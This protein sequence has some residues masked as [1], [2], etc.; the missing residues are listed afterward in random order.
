M[1]LKSKKPLKRGFKWFLLG[2]LQ[3]KTKNISQQALAW[4]GRTSFYLWL[5]RFVQVFS[6]ML[7]D[8]I[9]AQED[10]AKD[11]RG[12]AVFAG[13]DV[14]RNRSCLKVDKAHG[15]A[16]QTDD[17]RD[18]IRTLET[19]VVKHAAAIK[20]LRKAE[21]KGTPRQ[22]AALVLWLVVFRDRSGLCRQSFRLQRRCN[23]PLFRPRFLRPDAVLFLKADRI[24]FPRTC[25]VLPPHDLCLGRKGRCFVFESANTVF[26]FAKKSKT[27]FQTVKTRLNAMFKRVS[28]WWERM[29]SNYSRRVFSSIF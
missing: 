12:G 11:K 18:S 19:V 8:R 28:A 14:G 23:P 16:I 2:G 21:S 25:N 13:H 29:D 1:A 3:L 15:R 22:E 10:A 6:A 20:K 26:N 5:H 4:A 24:F 9:T 7:W 17:C 27:S